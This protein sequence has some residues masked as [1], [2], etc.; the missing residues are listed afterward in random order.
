MD[1]SRISRLISA[2]GQQQVAA[3]RST[4]AERSREGEQGTGQTPAQT[5][6]EAVS[7]SPNFGASTAALRE[8]VQEPAPSVDK[9]ARLREQV[10]RGT[11]NPSSRDIADAVAR[12]L[13]A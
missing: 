1:I 13:L 7:L 11:Y 10:Q 12:E 9:V 3:P 6:T 2:L 4:S 5:S 8:P